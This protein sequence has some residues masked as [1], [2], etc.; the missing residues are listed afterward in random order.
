M[1]AAPADLDPES[2]VRR[3][4]DLVDEEAY[5]PLFDLFTDGVVYERPGQE[6]IEGKEAFE[7]FYYEG[8]PLEDGTHEVRT[9]VV[10]GDGSQG[11]D[12]PGT[13]EDPTVA[14]R[15][16]FSGTQDGETVRFGFADFH[17]FDGDRIGRRYTFTDRDEV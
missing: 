10:E 9:V 1:T 14:V 15:G 16:T 5:D 11:G 17:E 12:G 8:R 2:I 13:G 3:Y 6:P 4:Y 7:A